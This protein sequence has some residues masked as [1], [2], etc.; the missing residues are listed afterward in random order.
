M[1]DG[2]NKDNNKDLAEQTASAMLK[3]WDSLFKKSDKQTAEQKTEAKG[4]VKIAIK[5]RQKSLKIMSGLWKQSKLTAKAEKVAAATR[6]KILS[7]WK[8]LL[9]IGL[10]LMPT[11]YWTKLK[12]SMF[13]MWD[14]L[15]GLDWEKIKK[16]VFDGLVTT[17]KVLTK[18]VGKIAEIFFGKKVTDTDGKETG[19]LNSDGSFKRTGGMFGEDSSMIDKA[20]GMLVLSLLLNPLGTV[21]MG[22]KALKG[23]FAGLTFLT[24][25]FQAAGGGVGLWATTKAFLTAFTTSGILA[26]IAIVAGLGLA[27]KD[28]IFGYFKHEEWEA[29]KVASALGGFFGGI[30]EGGWRSAF[31]NSGKWAMMGAGTG[32]LLGLVPGAIAGGIIGAALGGIMGFVGGKKIAQAIDKLATIGEFLLKPVTDAFEIMFRDFKITLINPIVDSI[33]P[34]G[35]WISTKT[36]PIV[37]WFDGFVAMLDKAIFNPIGLFF[38]GLSS[39]FKIDGQAMKDFNNTNM[40]DGTFGDDDNREKQR[41]A[42]EKAKEKKDKEDKIAALQAE[43]SGM[44]KKK[45]EKGIFWD[46]DAETDEDFTVRKENKRKDLAKLSGKTYRPMVSQG[47]G[48]APPTVTPPTV[49]TTVSSPKYTKVGIASS[50]SDT[51]MKGTDWTALG[52]R[53]NIDNAILSVWNKFKLPKAPTF[54]SG[55]RSIDTNKKAGVGGVKNSQ[56][57]S[58]TAFDLRNKDIPVGQR[59]SIASALQGALGGGL[60]VLRHKE[61]DSTS[62]PHFHMQLAAEGYSGIVNSPKMFMVGENGEELVNVTPLRSPSDRTV[63][64]NSLQNQNLDGQRMGG[65]GGGTTVIAPQSTKVSQSSTTAVMSAPTAKDSFWNN[66][67]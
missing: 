49:T 13:K 10:F 26:P 6:D 62:F 46:T 66:Q 53:N 12:D 28:G 64:L 52:G 17:I 15:K 35:K 22:F 27:I 1:V 50:V 19:E 48:G 11:E 31:T 44:K 34:I 23:I 2:V 67:V 33:E 59:D 63:A 55:L 43:I 45:G 32:F 3:S 39:I 24:T 56:H 21:I 37:D 16:N 18:V 57:L 58:G 30:G 47:G 8:L 65:G 38:R 61:L 5:E 14:Y 40:Y 41:L 36:K 29:S 51:G 9:G 7:K 60:K 42:R 4:A 20:K 25:S 54:T